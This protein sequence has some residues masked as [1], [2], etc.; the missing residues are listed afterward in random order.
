VLGAL[1]VTARYR[2]PAADGGLL[3][4]PPLDHL[5]DQLALN[6]RRLDSSPVRIAGV[7]LAEF[8]R[9]AVEE[10][11][12]AAG[13]YMAEGGEPTPPPAPRLLVAGHQPDFFHP[14]VWVKKFVLHGL[15]VRHGLAPLNLVVDNDVIKSAAVR[16]PVVADEPGGVRAVPVAF[17]RPA[18]DRPH[19]EYRVSDRTLFHTFPERLREYTRSWGF[20]P[21]AH[22][23]WP[24]MGVELDR[25]AT[26]GTAASRVRRSLERRWGVTNFELPVSRMAETRA[27]A[28]FVF[29]VLAGAS[30]FRSAYNA[31][32]A[33]YRKRN[34]VRSRN[35]PAPEL[36]ATATSVEAPFWVWRTGFPR[37][38][39]LFV[40][41]TESGLVLEAGEEVI[42][43]LPRTPDGFAAAWDRVLAQGSKV[44][45]RALSLT[46]FARLC[47]G[48]GFIHGI[49][50]GTYDEVTDDI[51]RR[52]FAMEPP[53]YAVVSATLRLP[54]RRFPT[55]AGELHAAERRV[56]DLEWNPQRFAETQ[57][58]FPELVARKAALIRE[59][60][61]AGVDRR[62]WF[63]QLQQLTRDMRPAVAGRLTEAEA[64]VGR[65]R[66]VLAANAILASR[67][68]A[69]PLFPEAML[70]DYF[71]R[72]R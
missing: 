64:A 55:T 20:E 39:R 6:A 71:A 53:G 7:P 5:G 44:R 3:A 48:D 38:Q 42:G 52:F 67:E 1:R 13:R 26:L 18:G 56:R 32:V 17:D 14:G 37:R 16:V 4:D 34:H 49:G 60:P 25:G 30:R 72:F 61:A 62:R 15:A 45:P 65:T 12:V 57:S 69:W 46:L 10:V 11:L 54:I 28:G 21:L 27:F 58:R 68:Y 22:E 33:D 9:I 2:A 51:V 47:L 23:V 19:E 43:L 8:R 35:H 40:R 31:A 70:R 63:R 41:T 36:E 66:H 50:G 29:T 59:K 24:M